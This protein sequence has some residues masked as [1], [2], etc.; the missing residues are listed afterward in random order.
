M[1]GIDGYGLLVGQGS[2]A[3][4]LVLPSRIKWKMRMKMIPGDAMGHA[5]QA[6]DR[7]A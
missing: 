2:S 7:F 1:M 3:L 4:S 5:L 6:G